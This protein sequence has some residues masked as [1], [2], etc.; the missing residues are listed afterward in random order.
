MAAREDARRLG[1]SKLDDVAELAGV[2]IAT[3]DRVLNERG[4]VKPDTAR[5]VLA[6]ARQLHLRRI[7]PSAH[8]R[9]LRFEVLLTR[10]DLPLMGRMSRAFASL[11]ATLDRTVI[12]QRNLLAG[13]KPEHLAQRMFATNYDAVITYAPEAEIILD[14]SAHLL[15]AGIPL[16]T[17]ISD[18]PSTARLAYAGPDHFA[19][20]RTAGYFIARMSRPGVV[21]VLCNHLQYHSHAQRVGGLRQAIADHA[22]HLT[23]PDV[24]E[25]GD[26]PELSEKLLRKTLRR[27]RDVSAIYNAGAA[28]EAVEAVLTEYPPPLRPVFVGHELTEHTRSMILNGIMALT[29]DQNPERQAHFAIAVLLQHFGRE[30]KVPVRSSLTSHLPFTLHGPYN[31]AL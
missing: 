19:S 20:G 7:L 27:R 10:P 9:T 22:P 8:Q 2:G 25:G 31:V 15:K 30:D 21:V 18:L 1:R 16:V 14:A 29:I 11:A 17:L 5:R 3:V 26:Q 23:V 24:L 13:E 6:A 28:H 4:G 12:V